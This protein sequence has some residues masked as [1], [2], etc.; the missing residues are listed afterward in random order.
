MKTFLEFLLEY[1]NPTVSGS[2][3]VTDMY[4]F[5]NS[6]IRKSDGLFVD[7]DMERYESLLAQFKGDYEGQWSREGDVDVL[8]FEITH[9]IDGSTVRDNV[10][11]AKSGRTKEAFYVDARGVLK[12]M[13]TS[14]QKRVVTRLKWE[15]PHDAV[16]VSKSDVD[17]SIS[18]GDV[19]SREAEFLGMTP[20]TR[21]GGGGLK[22][23]L[24]ASDEDL[25]V[26][27][28]RGRLEAEPGDILDI[29]FLVKDIG[30]YQGRKSVTGEKLVVRANKT[31]EESEKGYKS[32]MLKFN[33]LYKN[34]DKEAKEFLMDKAI[35]AEIFGNP[36]AAVRNWPRIEKEFHDWLAYRGA[37]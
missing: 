34:S 30:V 37:R 26:W 23:K 10:K 18:K 1:T 35:D 16:A 20:P 4:R 27:S 12:V 6:A 14:G 24:L 25:I 7:E 15:R 5:L 33:E 28:Y 9:S 36:K 22:F 11:W 3:A 21:Y 13:K 19:V 31:K 2:R 8:S 32:L 29:E 17:F